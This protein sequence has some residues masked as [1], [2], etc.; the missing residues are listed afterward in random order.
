M[1]EWQR[2]YSMLGRVVGLR[3]PN[4]PG[5]LHQTLHNMFALLM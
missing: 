3:E 4:K 2:Y 1:L 5:A